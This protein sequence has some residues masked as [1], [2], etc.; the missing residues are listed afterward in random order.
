M[1]DP[2]KINRRDF[3]KISAGTGAG[4]IIGISFAGCDNNQSPG[5]EKTSADSFM[6]SAW[7]SI[8]PDNTITIKIA[9]VDMGQGVMT[10]L[11][12]LI[13]EELEAD[14]SKIKVEHAPL[15]P[16]YGYQVTGGSDTI[17]TS[18]N[19]LR[20][21]GAIAKTML[22]AAAA[23]T[24]NVPE[25][26]CIAEQS[27][28]VHKPSQRKLSYGELAKAA[29]SVPI[30]K[31]V[32]LKT[33]GQFRLLGQSMPRL[34]NLE[35]INGTAVYGI[36]VM[37]PGLLTAAIKHC[38]V[39]GGKLK[40][41]DSGN[42]EKVSGVKK[43]VKLEAAVA[44]VA[45]NYWSAQKGLQALNIVWD[46]GPNQDVSSQTIST[47]L[48][49]AVHKNEKI[50]QNKGAAEAVIN[51][52]SRIVEAVYELPFQAHATMEPM[53]CT[54]YVK[55]GK[56]DVWVSTQEPSGA[57]NTAFNEVFSGLG[58][59]IEKL[60]QRLNG[61]RLESVRIH[62]T[63]IGGGF[64]RRF[65]SDYVSEA[66]KIAK[67]VDAPVKLIWSREEDIQ[68]DFY[69]P[70]TFHNMKAALDIEGLPAAWIH[71][72]AGPKGLHGASFLYNIEN[73]LT[74]VSSID[75]IVPLGAWRSIHHS[76]NAFAIECFIDELAYAAKQDPVDYRLKLLNKDERLKNVVELVAEKSDWRQP[77]PEGHFRGI[78]ALECF[79]SYV[80]QVAEISMT[81]TDEVKVHR[82][83]CAF[84][85]GLMVNPDTVRAQIEGGILFGLT[86]AIKSSITIKDGRV[87][88]SNFHDFQLIRLNETPEID[89]HLVNNTSP[90]GGVGETPV[91]PIA[92]AVANAVFAATGKRIRSL[93]VT[94]LI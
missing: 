56:C 54:A 34:D 31:S 14:W 8:S 86:A 7:L 66:I 65:K 35:K 45:D 25:S 68:H 50:V 33:P 40:S 19:T 11:P 67:S 51:G 2:V 84:D 16:A 42:A 21:A 79:G 55:D 46:K 94:K 93:P 58:K 49:Q 62:K 88:Q 81:K 75:N 20:N 4:F 29:S 80:A 82:V 32:T 28:I 92:P 72:S 39:F 22:L 37:L 30:P 52:S 15:E 69:R 13:A 70:V 74:T 48:Q 85:C 60:K 59:Q 77:A 26:E 36:D 63:A 91:P 27:F 6:P 17:R 89:I 73:V 61:G 38:P 64:G 87:E 53:N 3:L 24:W 76:F 41:V 10:A 83:V 1:S 12:M 57:Q 9:E 23:K 90:P 44:V 18:W 5:A 47:S 78:A 43:V 71:Q